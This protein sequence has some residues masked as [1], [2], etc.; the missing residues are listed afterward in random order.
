M[1]HKDRAQRLAYLRDWKRRNR[2]SPQ[3]QYQPDK[4]LPAYGVMVFSMDGAKVQCHACGRW[5]G[6]LNTHLKIHDL[7]ARSYKEL[8]ALPRTASLWPPILRQKQRQAAI[9]RD[10]GSIG[11]ANIPPLVG[12]PTGQTPRLGVRIAASDARKGV[13][14]RG[15]ETTR[16]P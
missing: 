4:S 1:P 3:P 7:D 10:Q 2:P 12:R 11:R 14:T 15:G 8:F 9:D 5:F 16:E 6:S 13:Y